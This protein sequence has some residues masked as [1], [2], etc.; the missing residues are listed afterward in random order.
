MGESAGGHLAALA[1]LRGQVRVEGL[2]S[3]YGIHDIPL[4]AEQQA[5]LPRNIGQYLAQS[6]AEALREASPVTYVHKAQ[7]P[8]LLVHGTADTGV[9]W[10]PSERLCEM[11]SRAGAACEIL[12]ITGAPHGVERWEQD[13]RFQIWKPKV[14]EW[15]RRLLH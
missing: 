13:E 6:S 1:A 5:E 10:Q 7:P 14:T 2:V 9:P 3:F 12:L 4:W 11:A 8:I 15:L